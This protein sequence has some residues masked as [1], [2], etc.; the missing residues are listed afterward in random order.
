MPNLNK[1][2]GKSIG[3]C[4]PSGAGI[5]NAGARGGV[6]S[7]TA[8]AIGGHVG[9]MHA[10]HQPNTS[11]YGLSSRN[12][13]NSDPRMT[14]QNSSAN[15]VPSRGTTVKAP[16]SRDVS[17]TFLVHSSNLTIRSRNNFGSN[18]SYIVI[19][20]QRQYTYRNDHNDMHSCRHRES[21]NI[22]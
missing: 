11:K 16:M 15:N 2:R 12:H 17:D 8:A 1:I 13:H 21:V 22:I 14:Y 5:P 3:G 6:S 19:N 7:K 10:M 20:E 9:G 4:V 18:I